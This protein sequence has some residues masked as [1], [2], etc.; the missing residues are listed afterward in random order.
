M[1]DEREYS[2]RE[3]AQISDLYGE[4][5]M[6]AEAYVRNFEGNYPNRLKLQ[7][8]L[9][10]IEAFRK[11]VP[12]EVCSE[13]FGRQQKVGEAFKPLVERAIELLKI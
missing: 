8:M 9:N 12:Q 11:D 4:I 3:V 2:A 6:G 1:T 13:M 7:E 10:L 5:Q